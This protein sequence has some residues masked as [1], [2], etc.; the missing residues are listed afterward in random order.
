MHINGDDTD[1]IVSALAFIPPDDRSLWLR[2]AM[3]LKSELG[4][5]GREIWDAWSQGADSYNA[6]DARDVWRSVKPGGGIGLGTLFFEAKQHGWSDDAPRSTPSPEEVEQRRRRQSEAARIEA[7]KAAQIRAEVAQQAGSI[8][9]AARPIGADDPHPYLVRKAV[10][11]T[12]TLRETTAEAATEILG[13]APKL[14]D[15]LL[16]GRLL[17]VPLQ[18]DGGLATLELIDESGRKVGLRGRGTRVGAYWAPVR[19]PEGDGSGLAILLA[20]GVATTLSA[21]QATG[22]PCVAGLGDNNLP[23]VARHLRERFPR[24][25]I[26]VLADLSKQTGE[27]DTFAA[28]A[29]RDIGAALAAPDFGSERSDG[30]TDFNDLHRQHGLDAVCRAIE[31]AVGSLD[32]AGEATH[33]ELRGDDPGAYQWMLDEAQAQSI[34]PTPA[35][36]EMPTE[37]S[38][39]RLC[40]LSDLRSAQLDPPEF[41]VDPLIPRGHLTLFGGHGGSGKSVVALAIS[42]HV[43]CG[44]S[45]AGLPAA[46]GRVMFVSFEDSE[47]LVKWR[48]KQIA[49]EYAL[50]YETIERNLVLIDATKSAPIEVEASSKGVKRTV[51]TTDGDDLHRRMTEGRFDLVVIDNASDAYGGEENNRQQVRG[52]VRRLSACVEPHNGAVLLLAHIDKSAARYGAAGNSYSGST[53]WHNS[54]RSRLALV[55]D[56]LRQEKLN[57]GK[58]LQVPI[59]LSWVRSVPVPSSTPGAVAQQA[60]RDADDEAAVIACF[61]AASEAGDNIPSSETGQ[62]TY[63]LAL[64]K[65]P[66]CPADLRSDKPRIKA[67]VTRL[68]RSGRIRREEYRTHDRKT[69]ER[70]IVREVRQCAP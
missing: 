14:R 18:A 43:A 4:E 30:A 21:Y 45:W 59:D 38:R 64:G 52:F 10:S 29:A 22:Y 42:A 33:G 7:E 6:G 54:A 56:R 26:A 63:V 49:H 61:L 15:E 65:Y 23:K 16:T 66:E 20:E 39:L 37:E 60:Q 69:K 2:A 25:R 36:N 9:R 32:A 67:T 27:P 40:D 11:A 3:A 8:W 28:K 24:A 44:R 70:L 55:D 35:A 68:L 51:T 19:L 62:N 58:R 57:V 13:Y 1:R 34:G 31:T 17:V 48:L 12:A 5:D 41:L 50:N 46:S 47:K 53:A